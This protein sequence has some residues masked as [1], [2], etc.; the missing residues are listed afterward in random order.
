LEKA[1]FFFANG[2]FGLLFEL[3]PPRLG[4]EHTGKTKENLRSPGWTA[5]RPL[6]CICRAVS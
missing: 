3:Y 2:H 4:P 5:E 6:D 1:T